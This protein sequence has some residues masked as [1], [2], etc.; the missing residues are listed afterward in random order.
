MLFDVLLLL[1]Q[2]LPYAMAGE[3][4]DGSL[5]ICDMQIDSPL[6]ARYYYLLHYA[7]SVVLVVIFTVCL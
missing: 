1:S 7:Y 4:V 6:K 2:V 5:R 3:A